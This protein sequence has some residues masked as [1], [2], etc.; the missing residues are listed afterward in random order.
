MGEPVPI[1]EQAN[2]YP[3]D[4]TSGVQEMV[5]LGQDEEHEGTVWVAWAPKRANPFSRFLPVLQQRHS[6][7]PEV[8]EQISDIPLRV[9][10][11]SGY[12][13]GTRTVRPGQVAPQT[14]AKPSVEPVPTLWRPGT[15]NLDEN[16]DKL[17]YVDD[18]DQLDPGLPEGLTLD[19]M[20]HSIHSVPQMSGHWYDDED[21][22]ATTIIEYS[23][24]GTAMGE[25][26]EP[27]LTHSTHSTT[28]RPPQAT[29]ARA[30]PP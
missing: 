5:D 24:T 22:D 9:S 14:P 4:F 26:V 10:L 25:G 27:L 30:L 2:L 3:G 13:F 18:L 7:E 16:R 1:G 12:R 29:L 6:E 23:R 17:D 21:L 15:L 20:I 19:D 28:T 11:A 8:S